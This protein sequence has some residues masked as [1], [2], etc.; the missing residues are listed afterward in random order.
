MIYKQCP[1]CSRSFRTFPCRVKR[2]R[3]LFCT[4]ACFYKAWKAFLARYD[5]KPTQDLSKAA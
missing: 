3:K 1:V 5:E 4:R 2:R